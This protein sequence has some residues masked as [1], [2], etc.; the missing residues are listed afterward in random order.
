MIGLAQVQ[1]A[2]KR[3]LVHSTKVSSRPPDLAAHGLVDGGDHSSSRAVLTHD[4]TRFAPGMEADRMLVDEALGDTDKAA[5]GARARV[6][7]PD[8]FG[9]GLCHEARIDPVP[10]KVILDRA[11]GSEESDIPGLT[12]SSCQASTR[13]CVSSLKLGCSCRVN[14]I[15][16]VLG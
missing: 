1:R 12:T 10:I 11:L 14:E 15:H 7:I 13:N 16:F 8:K 3:L 6:E 9:A 5:P 2:R 4:S